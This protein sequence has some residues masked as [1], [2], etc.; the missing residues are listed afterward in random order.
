LIFIPREGEE[1]PSIEEKGNKIVL[2]TKQIIAK[3][4]EITSPDAKGLAEYEPILNA[5]QSAKDEGDSVFQSVDWLKKRSC[6]LVVTGNLDHLLAG[7]PQGASALN[8]VEV[9][10]QPYALTSEYVTDRF[11]FEGLADLVAGCVKDDDLLYLCFDWGAKVNLML[12]STRDP[13]DRQKCLAAQDIY[14]EAA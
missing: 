5:F 8:A 2:K 11:E 9:I 7:V 6:A 13:G 1:L 3:M 10:G 14:L 4:Y 12:F